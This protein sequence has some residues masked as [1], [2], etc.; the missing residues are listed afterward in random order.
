MNVVVDVSVL[1]VCVSDNGDM[2]AIEWR[3]LP[4]SDSFSALLNLLLSYCNVKS[5]WKSRVV[6]AQSDKL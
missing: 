4:V 6:L 1:S 3:L 5:L 2:R